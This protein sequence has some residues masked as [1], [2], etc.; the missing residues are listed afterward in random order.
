MNEVALNFERPE[1]MQRL[2]KTRS[3]MGRAGVELLI[4]TDPS[5]MSWLTGYDG[6]SFYTHQCVLVAE[7]G[8]PFWFG[9]GM[10]AKGA[11]RTVYMAPDH[12]IGYA[13]HYVQSVE[14]HPMDRLSE[15]IIATGSE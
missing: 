1:Y 3:A 8:D 7:Q 11:L 12:I 6:W 2:A 10:D 14:R 13:D 4:V 5:N 15:I 9:R